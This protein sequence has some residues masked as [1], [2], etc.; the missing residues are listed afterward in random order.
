MQ[1]NSLFV[2][3][4]SRI[5]E[6]CEGI[7]LRTIEEM[8]KMEK[9]LPYYEVE[10]TLQDAQISWHRNQRD[11]AKSLLRF[12]QKDKK[13]PDLLQR[14]EAFRIYGE[15]AAQS[16]DED[17]DQIYKNYF[18]PSMRALDMYAKQSGNSELLNTASQRELNYSDPESIKI[19]E[20]LP[21]FETIAKYYDRQYTQAFEY[22]ESDAYKKRQENLERNSQVLKALENEIQKIPRNIENKAVLEDKHKTKIIL[23][24]N[25]EIDEEELKRL[26]QKRDSMSLLAMLNYTRNAIIDPSLNLLS[27]FRIISLW[28]NNQENQDIKKLL[29]TR[30]V[31]IS[32]HKFIPA[33]PQLTSRLN[34]NNKD[35]VKVL[36]QLLERCAREHPHHTIMLILNLV[37]ANVDSKETNPD[38][39]T[40]LKVA[41]K[42]ISNLK[43][44]HK[45]DD[46]IE[47]YQTMALA[48]ID[49]ANI[50]EITS[51]PKNHSLLK[52]K[53]Y[54]LVHC[55]TMDLPVVAG[56]WIDYSK[57]IVSVVKWEE[58]MALVGG[59]N[60]PKKIFCRCSDGQVRSQL[61]K[62]QDD[63]RQ[64]AVMEQV[65]SIINEIFRE[66]QEI[67]KYQ[68]LIR[69]YKIVPL[70]RRS[71]ILEWCEDCLPIGV[72]L[73][74][75]GREPGA[76]EK[77]RP[78]DWTVSKCRATMRDLDNFSDKNKKL[79]KYLEIYENFK[80][81]FHHFFLESFLQPG[82]WFER[83]LKYIKS[84][85][86]TSIVG[87]ILGIGD[88]HVQNIL[89]DKGSGEVVHIDFG[90]AFEQGKILP[91]AELIPFRL[92]RDIIAPM[93][94]SGVNGIF[95]KLCEKILS[96]LRQNEVI[97]MTILDVLLY[98]PLYAWT[99]TTSKAKRYQPEAF[100]ISCAC[101]EDTEKN[102]TASRA[103]MRIQNKL[104]GL[105][106]IS[107]GHSCV[108]GQI[109]R[110]IL[111][112]TNPTILNKLFVGWQ[113][114]L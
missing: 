94:I 35:T 90:I 70:S 114:Y 98:D 38:I 41:K 34:E 73:V 10:L 83:R 82:V 66:S 57:D 56:T 67:K 99:M 32:S 111:D 23:K 12:V 68:L 96:I 89:I 18:D 52:I 55:P 106:D 9:L 63:L 48:M 19:L 95:K 100:G 30:M 50:K 7:A 78:Q 20:Y 53:N 36:T 1:K 47:Q 49:L 86:T 5:S 77:L 62:G 87:Y 113:P 58:K 8:R 110:L 60:A 28:L 21:I 39:E 26:Q 22:M 13:S 42:I 51:I 103:L 84:V 17:Y 27:I 65:F 75:S 101:S 91:H 37:N 43:A 81:V 107:S 88:R 105:D 69:T 29:N 11:L 4:Q 59:I 71:G 93:G 31:C 44:D 76:H 16:Q 108:E 61:L 109:E 15:Y 104:R 46:L 3:K 40:R 14:S 24:R 79:E 64:D 85:A 2:I 102:S 6:D 25:R 74:G 72:Y 33:L 45:M 92:T 80:P 112:A 97:I 54:N